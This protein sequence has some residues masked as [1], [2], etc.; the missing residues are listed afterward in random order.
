MPRNESPPRIEA[1]SIRFTL[2]TNCHSLR[3]LLLVIRLRWIDSK[4][5]K[6]PLT[7]VYGIQANGTAEDQVFVM[8]KTGRSQYVHANTKDRD[9]PSHSAEFPGVSADKFHQVKSKP[10]HGV[11]AAIV[12]R[13]EQTG[14]YSPI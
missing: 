5:P 14:K 11:N 2:M 9:Y 7:R 1:A 3:V 12:F 4:L 10:V 13:L 6:Y 8:Q